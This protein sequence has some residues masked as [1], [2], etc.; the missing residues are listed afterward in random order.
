MK[1]NFVLITSIFLL[2]LV[3]LRSASAQDT[4][5]DESHIDTVR[6]VVLMP[7]LYLYNL[8]DSGAR[9]RNYLVEGD[10]FSVLKDKGKHWLKIAYQN[11]RYGTVTKWMNTIENDP[12]SDR[13]VM[14]C[15]QHRKKAAISMRGGLI[16][17]TFHLSVFN[18]SSAPVNLSYATV[19]L[20]FIS[21]KNDTMVLHHLYNLDF[22]LKLK[23]GA[24][25]TLDDNMVHFN[26][27]KNIYELEETQGDVPFYPDG[28]SG[29]YQMIP[30]LTQ[31][32]LEAPVYAE[33]DTVNLNQ[34]YRLKD[35][36]G[37]AILPLAHKITQAATGNVSVGMLEKWNKDLLRNLYLYAFDTPDF[38]NK[39]FPEWAAN[40]IRVLTSEDKKIRIVFW[41]KHTG[42][43]LRDYES[44]V[45]WNYDSAKLNG[46]EIEEA[47]HSSFSAIETV[48]KD[49]GEPIYLVVGMVHASNRNMVNYIRAY[50]VNEYGVLDNHVKLFRRSGKKSNSI[51][52][53]L[54]RVPITSS[55]KLIHF[56]AR[57][58]TLYIP[59]VD[60]KGMVRPRHYQVYKFDGEMFVLRK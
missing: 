37:A 51:A 3:V 16:D 55:K 19:S 29:Q 41:N 45:F 50:Q 13:N 46:R 26:N 57:K 39:S 31:P 35:A 34:N 20:L 32:E 30:V 40:G 38:L 52:I 15:Y 10:I 59:V 9:T 49:G 11:P 60:D 4:S 23:P 48:H 44:L 12:M 43:M 7:R 25:Y 24:S 28:I 33:A 36:H 5:A 47:A 54:N 2:V 56:N 18:D 1:R 22:Y 27:E 42:G 58:N 17:G 6:G 21:L 14:L 8:P 53:E